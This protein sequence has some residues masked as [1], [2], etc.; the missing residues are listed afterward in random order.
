[1]ECSSGFHP[2]ST[3]TKDGRLWFSTVKGAVSV[4]PGTHPRNELAPNV[5]IEEMRIDGKP[6]E[7]L[8]APILLPPGRHSCEI[9]FTA[10]SLVAPEKVHFQWRLNGL[11][12]EW[13][14]GGTARSVRYSSLQRGAYSFHVR[15]CNNDG[16]WTE[17]RTQLRLEI[18][19]YYWQTTW[20]RIAAPLAGLSLLAASIWSLLR[21]RHQ[22]EMRELNRKQALE[23]E[24]TRIARDLHDDL[25]ASL[26]QLTWMC[27]ASDRQDG[28]PLPEIGAK[29][30]SMVRSIDE[31]VWAVNPKNDTLD[32]LIHYIC[33]FAEDFLHTTNIRCRLDVQDPLPDCALASTIRHDAFLIAREA[34]HNAARHSEATELQIKI[35]TTEKEAQISITDN[36]KG[37]DPTKATNG[38]GLRN[39]QARAK[40]LK[41][42]LGINSSHSKGSQV[43]IYLPF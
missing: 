39:M 43:V 16:V 42:H 41:T 3:Q 14:D 32:G 7:N 27:E 23:A 34:I 36:G 25:G 37:F 5:F 13:V 11:E 35:R 33:Q 6:Q 20:F 24:R 38:N 15:A 29:A 17:I 10:T 1:M 8:T 4:L 18:A 40:S 9:K 22:Q 21:R 30:R 31:I 26:T 2:G 12:N 28:E 19:P